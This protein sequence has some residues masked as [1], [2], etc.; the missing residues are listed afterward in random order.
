MDKIREQ[1]DRVQEKI[2]EQEDRLEES[3]HELDLAQ[4]LYN[5][6]VEHQKVLAVGP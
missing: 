5:L 6:C 3:L 4:N 2:T 1:M